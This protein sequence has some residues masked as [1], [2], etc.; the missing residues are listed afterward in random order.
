[1]S[2][3]I[4]AEEFRKKYCQSLEDMSEE[5]REGVYLGRWESFEKD[6]LIHKKLQEYYDLTP[7]EVSNKRAH[8]LYKEFLHWAKTRGYSREDITRARRSKLGGDI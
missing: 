2:Y 4:S 5:E 1:M 6:E 7:N 3:D 8:E